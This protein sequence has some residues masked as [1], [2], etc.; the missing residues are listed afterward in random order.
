MVNSLENIDKSKVDVSRIEGISEEIQTQITNTI[1]G[2]ASTVITNDLTESRAVVSSATGKIAVSAVTSTELGYLD[3]V[4]SAIQTQ[5]N[6]KQATLE[7]GTNIKTV[8][9]TSL[10]GSGD[11]AVQAVI[12][13]AASTITSSNL[14]ANRALIS[15]N[16]GK[17]AVSSITSTKLGYL[18]D[19]TSNIQAQLNSKAGAVVGSIIAYAG[20]T[21]PSG[22]LLCDGSA[23]SR[24]TYSALFSAIGTTYGAG[25]GNS[26]FNIPSQYE[27][28]F[29]ANRSNTYSKEALTILC[30]C[31]TSDKK[32]IAT[33]Y[34][35][36]K[37]IDN[38]DNITI[39]K[40]NCNIRHSDGGYLLGGAA[41]G[42]KDLL[43]YISSYD[44]HY[45]NTGMQ[46][47]INFI[48][49]TAESSFTNNC[50]V[51]ID[52]Y[53]F[54]ISFTEKS[55]MFRTKYEYIRY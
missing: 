28:A 24:T 53:D 31:L 18:T 50:P 3:G 54:G 46:L 12:T 52:L 21:I 20:T 8:N 35:F 9:S 16:S 17:I 2:A 45:S 33:S 27:Y 44:I 7:S 38:I 36:P 51:V 14:T 48:L 19:V 47:E 23:I 13:G 37:R 41:S 5:L 55:R 26:T 32:K 39:T 40:F 43:S 1:T 15:N 11:V 42:G 49:T 6:G 22:Y 29:D 4:T 25:D 10:L 30:G 34:V